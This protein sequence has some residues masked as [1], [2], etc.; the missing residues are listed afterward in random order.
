[1]AQPQAN[2]QADA[3]KANL[4]A[5]NLI[6]RNAVKRTQRIYSGTVDP[7]TNPVLNIEPQNAGLILGF[8]INVRSNIAVGGTGSA[9]TLTP[10]GAS[11]LLSQVQFDDLSNNTRIKTPG[12]HLGLIDAARS[13]IPYLGV[14]TLDAYPVDFDN[15]DGTLAQAADTIGQG[16]NSDVAF[17]YYV[18]IA[19]S[20]DDLRGAIWASVVSAT[21]NLQLSL[22][23]VATAVQAR[24]QSGGSDAIYVTAASGTPPAEITLGNFSIDI[25]QVY[26]DQ[27]PEINV[28]GRMQPLLPLDDLSTFY[29]IKQTSYTGLSANQAFPIPYSNYRDYLATYVVYRNRAAAKGAQGF[30]DLG[31]VTEWLLNTANFTEV[32]RVQDRI[33]RAW[34]RQAVEADFPL[35]SYYFPS[36]QKT[37]STKTFGNMNLNITAADVQ[38][39]AACLVAYESFGRLRQIAQAAGIGGS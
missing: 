19:Y 4:A 7:A 25:Y 38:T 31:D 35:G 39:G 5:R 36:R 10:F 2:G 30:V 32:W 3:M 9:L 14:Q 1:M 22:N 11:N 33:A 13:G 23:Q 20:E 15:H 29:D 24:T 27:L 6:V 21:M 17:T 18:P 12:W 28:N 16:A 37:I 34:G 8:V 26:Y